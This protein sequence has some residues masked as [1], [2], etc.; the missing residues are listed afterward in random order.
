MVS[1]TE[2]IA[3]GFGASLCAGLATGVGAI[4][5]AFVSRSSEKLMDGLLGFAAGIMLAAAT[6][7]LITPAIDK[8]GLGTAM[9]GLLLGVGLLS[10][11]DGLVPHLHFISGPEG[12]PTHLR[13]VWLFVLALTIHNLPEGLAVGVSFGPGDIAAGIIFAVG[14]GIQN[15]PEGLAVSL[16]L[17]REGYDSKRAIGYAT[18][19][20]LVEPVTGLLGVS[21]VVVFGPLLPMGLAFAGGAMLYVL[22][23]ELIPES[24]RRGHDRVATFGTVAGF[25]L[26]T[27]LERLFA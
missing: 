11:V 6:F 10:L 18:L 27:A 25:V 16:P 8:G 15:M 3:I 26:M 7:G 12:P 23:D 4:P 17:V 1:H 24:H 5:A 19:T 13:R 9:V 22:I 2:L 20:G 21:L 14:I